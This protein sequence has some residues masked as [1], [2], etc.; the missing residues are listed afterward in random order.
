[1]EE[2]SPIIRKADVVVVG[3]T[4]SGIACAVRCAREGLKVIVVNA[5]NHLG[6]V[7]SSGLGVTDNLY[8]G[9]RAPIYE[10]FIQQ[11]REYYKRTY[12]EH[13]QQA[14]DCYTKRKLHFEPH[15]AEHVFTGLVEA[16][17]RISV[18]YRYF[19]ISVEAGRPQTDS[20]DF[21]EL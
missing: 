14:A 19:P 13:S 9:F 7:M 16:E 20:R 11:V 5:T 15:V 8:D 2:A 18:L 3:G 10:T 12:G 21:P 6:G 4:P 17:S 1:M